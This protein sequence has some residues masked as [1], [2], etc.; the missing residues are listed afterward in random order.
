MNEYSVKLTPH[1]IIQIQEAIAYISKVLLAPETAMLW[2]NRLE[3][4]IS[5]LGTM[6]ARFPLTDREPWK[7]IGYRKM[8]VKNFLVYYFTDEKA[9]TVWVT[10]VVYAKRDQLNA[11]KEIPTEQDLKS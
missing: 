5:K 3:K 10:T 11:L 2:A 4:E 6:P 1:A 8:S 7:T 9:K